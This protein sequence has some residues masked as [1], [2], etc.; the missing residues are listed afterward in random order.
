MITKNITYSNYRIN[1][2]K[3]TINFCKSKHWKTMLKGCFFLSCLMFFSS[4]KARVPA[5][6]V[7]KASSLISWNL[8]VDVQSPHGW[9]FHKIGVFPPKWMVKIMENPI[10]MDDLGGNPLFSVKQPFMTVN[11]SVFPCSTWLV[12]PI[13]WMWIHFWKNSAPTVSLFDKRDSNKNWSSW[14]LCTSK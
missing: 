7:G 11:S 14:W 3:N 4:W 13:L 1:D 5:D 10:K 2:S 12:C 9:N 6:D 8:I